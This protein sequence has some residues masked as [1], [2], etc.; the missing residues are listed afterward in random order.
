MASVLRFDDW[1]TTLGT[2]VVS[3]DGSGN[4]AVGGSSPSYKLDVTGDI[5]ASGALRIGGTSIGAYTATTF[6]FTA[7]VTEGNG[8][9]SGAYTE[10]NDL[11][12]EWFVFT[13]GSTS[14]VTGDITWTL[15]IAPQTDVLAVTADAQF[16]DGGDIY[17]ASCDFGS[18]ARVFMR[19]INTS[20]TYAVVTN[21][22]ST[23]PFTWG[24]GD[25]IIGSIVYQK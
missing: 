14:A 13:L 17:P 19:A 2:G 9:W 23:I 20:G 10:I 6:G 5:N 7:N 25:A 21:A 11:V 22:S 18:G 12:H 8:T 3:T 24:T 1:E 4:V 16:L 15:T